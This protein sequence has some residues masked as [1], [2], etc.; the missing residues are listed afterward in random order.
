MALFRYS[1]Y[2]ILQPQRIFT[3]FFTEKVGPSS[4]I[5][6]SSSSSSSVITTF[7]LPA[8]ANSALSSLSTVIAA[9]ALAR[10]IVVIIS[11]APAEFMNLLSHT[12]AQAL[13][14][15][16]KAWCHKPIQKSVLIAGLN[17]SNQLA[18]HVQLHKSIHMTQAGAQLSPE[19]KCSVCKRA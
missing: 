7:L 13:S 16:K 10:N 6:S 17:N 12:G 8:Q 11:P 2:L 15:H 18:I 5:A 19:Q 14:A 4:I 3:P 9:P 1:V